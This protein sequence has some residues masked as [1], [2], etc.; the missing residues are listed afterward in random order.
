MITG[1]FWA[2]PFEGP[3]RV[4]ARDID[5]YYDAH[6]AW[7]ATMTELEA[8]GH[9]VEFRM[10]PGTVSVFN[11]RRMLHGRRS[12]ISDTPGQER[13]LQGTYVHV[14]EFKSRLLTLCSRYGGFEDVRRVFNQQTL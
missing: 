4:P 13:V 9:L 11:N 3:L 2:P 12:F 10:A 7:D 1:I 14:D 6:L 5:A 8:E